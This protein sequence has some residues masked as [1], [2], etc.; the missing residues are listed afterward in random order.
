MVFKEKMLTFR[1]DAGLMYLV[2]Q[3][4][5]QSSD[6]ILGFFYDFGKE[7]FI[8]GIKN[9]KENQRDIRKNVEAIYPGTAIPFLINVEGG[10]RGYGDL[11]YGGTILATFPSNPIY[12]ETEQ[13]LEMIVEKNLLGGSSLPPFEPPKCHTPKM[14]KDLIKHVLEKKPDETLCD[15]GHSRKIGL[16]QETVGRPPNES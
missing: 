3:V 5:G 9:M 14:Y 10:K 12:M 15:S 2:Q 7:I 16:T 1:P 11:G 6:E 8:I 4:T 13:L